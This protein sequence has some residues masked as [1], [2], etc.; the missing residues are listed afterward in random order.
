MVVLKAKGVE[1]QFPLFSKIHEIAFE[2]KPVS[3][4]VQI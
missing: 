4:I 3:E 1:D 2:G